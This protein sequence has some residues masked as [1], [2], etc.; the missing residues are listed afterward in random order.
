MVKVNDKNVRI[1]GNI[2]IIMN[3]WMNATRVI[4]KILAKQI[5]LRAASTMLGGGL[6][7]TAND[8]ADELMKKGELPDE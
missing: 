8:A 6:Q 3:D 5:G 7:V 4:Y 2:K 1:E